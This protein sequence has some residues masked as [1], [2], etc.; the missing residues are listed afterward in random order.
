MD[1]S[2]IFKPQDE[3]QG[4]VEVVLILVLAAIVVIAILTLLGP[5][6]CTIQSNIIYSL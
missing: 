1:S 6:T 2:F 3:G 5:S 4:I